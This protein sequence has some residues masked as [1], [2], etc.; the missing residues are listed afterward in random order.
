MLRVTVL[1]IEE[2]RLCEELDRLC[3]KLVDLRSERQLIV[4]S[5]SVGYQG[6]LQ[7]LESL[8]GMKCAPITSIKQFRG[9]RDEIRRYHD[10]S[11]QLHLSISEIEKGIAALVAA[12]KRIEKR[13]EEISREYSQYGRLYRLSL[14][15]GG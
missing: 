1:E 4:D 5:L 13:L 9:V 11:G 3:D 15:G 6:Y 2:N 10:V 14:K 12:A 7:A 8:E